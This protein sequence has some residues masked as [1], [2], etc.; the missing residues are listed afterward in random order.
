MKCPK[1]GNEMENGFIQS[2]H[3]VSWVKKPNKI[4]YATKNEDVEFITKVPFFIP[5]VPADICKKCREI[6]VHYSMR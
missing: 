6:V 2:P 3:H 5:A 4:M 1:C